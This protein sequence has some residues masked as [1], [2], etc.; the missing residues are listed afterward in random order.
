MTVSVLVPYRPDGGQRER[1]WEEF[2]R[3][4]WGEHFPE[5]EVVT[6]TCPDGPWVKS[7]AVA[8]ALSRASGDLLVLSDADVWTDGIEEAVWQLRDHQ[9][10]IPHTMVHRL[11]RFAT[12]D[13]MAG[14]PIDED[15]LD[16]PKHLGQL[17]GGMTAIRRKLYE[18]APIDP[19]FRG[20]GQEDW[21]AA[22]AWRAL[23]GAPWRGHDPLWHFWH[24]PM[25]RKNR[26][27]GSDESMRLYTRYLNATYNQVAM[28]RIIGEFKGVDS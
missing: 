6:G 23:G 5:W 25:P 1:V 12:D 18:E 4:K 3:G 20:W 14:L 11:S 22:L 19:R 2:L 9:W 7:L 24:P 13:V 21:A 15:D 10:A 26:S 8:D 27:V 28:R 17:A 16:E